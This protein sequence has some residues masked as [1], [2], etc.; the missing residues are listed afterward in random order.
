MTRLQLSLLGP[1]QLR[2]ADKLV[3]QFPT[4][5]VQ[6][7]LVYLAVEASVAHARAA[8]V[9]LFW[10]DYSAD[11][12]RQNLRKTLHRL[13]Q[14]IPP[15]YLITTNQTIQ[16]NL[17]SDYQLDV[18]VFT[19]LLTDCRRHPHADLLTCAVCIERLQQAVALYRGDFLAHFFVEES[20]AFEEWAFLKREWLRR[21]AL[22]ALY[23]LATYHERQGEYDCAYR[24]AWRQVELDPLR[25][26]AHQQLMRVLAFSGQRNEALAQ[27]ATCRRLLTAELAVEPGPTTIDLY[28]QIC[29][30]KL[31]PI[32]RWQSDRIYL[33]KV[34]SIQP[35]TLKRQALSPLPS[36]NALAPPAALIHLLAVLTTE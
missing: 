32:P 27:Y 29:A 8:L 15:D 1:W 35:V 34:P 10:A 12:A 11:S 28:K 16:F 14:T 24:Y 17:A 4:A 36:E 20:S 33:A 30:G 2:L 9:G 3:T 25:E 18:A 5:K 26:E 7:L 31:E 13:R 22:A 21:E 23:G 6:A 19:R